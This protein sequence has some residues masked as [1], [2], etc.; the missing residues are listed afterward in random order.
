M[1]ENN[2]DILNTYEIFGMKHQGKIVLFGFLITIIW[3]F[4]SIGTFFINWLPPLLANWQCQMA[5]D[6]YAWSNADVAYHIITWIMNLLL[7]SI[8]IL[9]CILLPL[10]K[11]TINLSAYFIEKRIDL[12][13]YHIDSLMNL[14][15]NLVG[16]KLK[17]MEQD[18]YDKEYKRYRISFWPVHI[19]I[20]VVFSLTFY[21]A[22][23]S[24][25]AGI[26][27]D[28]NRKLVAVSLT[29][30]NAVVN[31]L[32]YD[33]ISMKSKADLNAINKRIDDIISNRLVE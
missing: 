6:M 27:K 10:I 30:N 32:K 7:S 15:L 16:E 21:F 24:G 17:P 19:T 3:N 33:F 14:A 26:V 25:A 31:Q 8:L 11:N 9:L 18:S 29:E 5:A 1:E 28:F 2:N 20:I 4:L 22:Y 12:L 13:H 23:H